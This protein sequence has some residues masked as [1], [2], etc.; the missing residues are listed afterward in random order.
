V[1]EISDRLRS[2]V[3]RL[4]EKLPNATVLLGTVYDPSDGTNRLPGYQRSLNEEAQW[5]SDYNDFVGKLAGTDRHLRLAD[6]HAHFL[7]HGLTV[8]EHERWYLQ[9]SIIEPSARGASEVR[10]V[11]LDVLNKSI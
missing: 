4:L 3:E 9:E 6:I 10:R 2:A 7:G 8:P 1:P 5:L 11:W